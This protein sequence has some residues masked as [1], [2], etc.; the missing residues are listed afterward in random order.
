MLLLTLLWWLLFIK[1]QTCEIKIELE[2]VKSTCL[3]IHLMARGAKDSPN[4]FPHICSRSIQLSFS[5][6]WSPPN[7]KEGRRGNVS[8]NYHIYKALPARCRFPPFN[9]THTAVL[10]PCKAPQ[11]PSSRAETTQQPRRDHKQWKKG[12]TLFVQRKQT[13]ARLYAS[14]LNHR[15]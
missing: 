5:L 6:Y 10:N 15:G 13:C 14:S 2:T 3:S 12:T 11:S 1:I 7:V 9:L 4:T 8:P